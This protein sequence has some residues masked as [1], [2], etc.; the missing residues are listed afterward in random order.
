MIEDKIE[1]DFE[2]VAKTIYEWNLNFK[3]KD[4]KK[5]IKQ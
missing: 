3:S 5:V 1:D 4:Y 2:K